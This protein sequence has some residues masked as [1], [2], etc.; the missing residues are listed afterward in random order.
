MAIGAVETFEHVL[1]LRPGETGLIAFRFPKDRRKGLDVKLIAADRSA[2]TV[3]LA[4]EDVSRGYDMLQFVEGADD[5][6]WTP[7]LPGDDG[8]VH[9]TLDLEAGDRVGIV[10]DDQFPHAVSL[11]DAAWQGGVVRLTFR[12]QA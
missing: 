2:G 9:A 3:E 12:E 7:L 8:D 11:V 4:L 6:P 10:S 5:V 1:E